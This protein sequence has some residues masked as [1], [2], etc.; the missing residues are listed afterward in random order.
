MP[1]L[2]CA[3][4]LVNFRHVVYEE[5]ERADIQTHAHRHTSH[6]VGRLTFDVHRVCTV[7]GCRLREVPRRWTDG[8]NSR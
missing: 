1:Q 2:T 3:I 6:P 5:Q 8:L 4:N 7:K